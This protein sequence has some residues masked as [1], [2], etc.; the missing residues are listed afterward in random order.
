MIENS[1]TPV[2]SKRCVCSRTLL[3][4]IWSSPDTHTHSA[5]ASSH[6]LVARIQGV[7]ANGWC[8]CHGYPND[9]KLLG[10]DDGWKEE[11]EEEDLLL[12]G[13]QYFLWQPDGLTNCD[14][15]PGD[16]RGIVFKN[17]QTNRR[18]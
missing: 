4:N 10:C 14:I 13:A 12:M 16:C 11:E 17:D 2:K 9:A 8:G 5:I 7:R 1:I 6:L 3:A 15:P 18:F